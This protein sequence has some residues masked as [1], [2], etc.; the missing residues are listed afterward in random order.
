MDIIL[1]I[2]FVVRELQMGSEK[3]FDAP[4][5]LKNN[6]IPLE[7]EVLV[8]KHLLIRNLKSFYWKKE[9]RQQKKLTLS[10]VRLK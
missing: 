5:E 7:I 10:L 2:T 1:L 3:K 9:L 4:R 6:S 8:K